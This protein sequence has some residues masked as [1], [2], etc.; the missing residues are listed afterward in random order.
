[1]TLFQ[2]VREM[3]LSKAEKVQIRL[4]EEKG[5]IQLLTMGLIKELPSIW[6]KGLEKVVTHKAINYLISSALL[7][8]IMPTS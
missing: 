7:G 6:K 4:M 3:I 5:L 2:Q 1:M 8:L